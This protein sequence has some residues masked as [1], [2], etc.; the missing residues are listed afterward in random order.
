MK[1]VKEKKKKTVGKKTEK[2][3]KKE[4][5]TNQNVILEFEIVLLGENVPS[6]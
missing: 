4:P 2:K 3:K 6:E 5:E 1:A